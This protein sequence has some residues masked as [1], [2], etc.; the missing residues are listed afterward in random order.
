MMLAAALLWCRARMRRGVWVVLVLGAAFLTVFAACES[1]PDDAAAL[2]AAARE[3]MQ[4]ATFSSQID[5]CE[6]CA[7]P[8]SF[9][10]GPPDALMVTGSGGHDEWP[11][12]LY[13]DRKAYFS[14]AGVRWY[15]GEDS[16]WFVFLL[17]SDPR[18][19]LAAAIEPQFDGEATIDSR[20]ARIV[21]TKFSFD[22]HLANL[23]AG[24]IA[25]GD[26]GELRTFL[27]DLSLR[28]W[29]DAKD[30]R[31]LQMTITAPGQPAPARAMVFEYDRPVSI[32][33]AAQ[34]MDRDHAARLSQ[35]A[36]EGARTLLAAIAT[37]RRATGG[38]PARLDETTLSSALGPGAWP[39]NAFSGVA[40]RDSP[41]PGDFTYAVSNGGAD[42]TFSV[43]AWD[44]EQLYY[45]SA[46]FGQ[47]E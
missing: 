34:S 26:T 43:H 42:F 33:R 13:L 32:P 10:Y 29:I 37:H 31:V 12:Y 3:A 25:N 14:S 7:S 9:E 38:Y 20:P 1:E 15:T 6:S 5:A 19:M 24:I 36:E 44:N 39:R 22:G 2:V 8:T 35:Q 46:R 28:F 17:L 4:D 16:S 47:P 18:A 27:R 45:D 21:A 23:P 11:F 40:M 41:D 30:Y